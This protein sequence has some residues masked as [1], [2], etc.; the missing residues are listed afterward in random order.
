MLNEFLLRF[1]EAGVPGA[2]AAAGAPADPA[3]S[4]DAELVPIF[5]ALEATEHEADR[6][7]ADTRRQADLRRSNAVE[8]ARVL[9]ADANAGAAGEQAAQ[10]AL[11]FAR[12]DA[13]CAE[14]R[15]KSA[16]EVTRIEA[17]FPPRMQPLIAEIV[18]RIL[19][20]SEAVKKRM[21]SDWTAVA[22]RAR[23]LASRRLGRKGAV[24]LAHATSLA[25][26]LG[27]LAHTPP[28]V[29]MCAPKWILYRLSTR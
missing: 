23:G 4:I 17:T 9:L 22:V 1:R 25:E 27:M 29:M 6:Q 20:D 19:T 24:R 3:A 10:A 2:S 7:E 14:L 21:T 12:A 28:I 11:G 16:A 13:Q 26:A 18:D 5:A 8:Q 15:A